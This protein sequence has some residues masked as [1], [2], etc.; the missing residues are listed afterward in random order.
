[1]FHHLP[2]V[3]M[4]IH[5]FLHAD[6]EDLGMI[7]KWI[8]SK[9][10]S[11]TTTRFYAGDPLPDPDEIHWL[12]VMGGPMGAYDDER[13][14]WLVDERQCIREVISRSRTVLGI[15]LG[16]QIIAAAM[17]AR[18][19]RNPEREIGW[20][21]VQ[22]ARVPSI[23]NPL[24]DLPA[25]FPVFQWHGD[26]FQIPEG[27]ILLALSDACRNQAFT[28]DEKVLALQ[29]HLEL[30]KENVERLIENCPADLNPGAF[31]QTAEEMLSRADLF[32][33]SATMMAKILDYLEQTI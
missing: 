21:R 27:A 3:A 26:M 28:I 1:M 32:E 17:G 20:H 7:E 29:F 9:G 19:S 22:K 2:I 8:R 31:V 33:S 14:P 25:D 10:H 30:E 5:A 23:M 12:I 16:A 18:V 11:L 15:C 4:R 24:R 6:F 13:Y